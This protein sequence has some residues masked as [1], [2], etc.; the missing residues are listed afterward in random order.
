ME[1]PGGVNAYVI[2]LGSETHEATAEIWQ[3]TYFLA[4]IED[5]HPD[6]N[7]NGAWDA[8]MAESTDILASPE[9]IK[10]LSNVLKSNIS[11]CTSIEPLIFLDML[12]LYKAVSALISPIASRTPKVRQLRTVKK[13]LLKLMETY[14]QR[15][16]D[17]EG[18]NSSFIPPLLDVVLGD[19][20]T[21]VPTAR[22]AEVLG[23]TTIVINR[24][25]VTN[26][27]L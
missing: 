21:N 23:L 13:D 1:I 2:D 3:E 7:S 8:L 10:L 9:N 12:G 27:G 17:L 16:D 26:P 6:A 15:A 25:Q 5:A 14:I 4:L 18:V 11:G 22:D 24:L 20:S 19:Y